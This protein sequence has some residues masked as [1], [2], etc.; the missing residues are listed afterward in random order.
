MRR[1]WPALAATIPLVL[2]WAVATAR[3]ASASAPATGPAAVQPGG[4]VSS[5]STPGMPSG[6]VT[7]QITGPQPRAVPG[8]GPERRRPGAAAPRTPSSPAATGPAT[9]RPAARSPARRRTGRS[10]PATATARAAST[11]RSGSGS[12]A[13]PAPRSS[14]SAPR[15]T[16]RVLPPVLRLVRGL[17]GRGGELHQPGQPRRPVLRL[18]HLPAPSTFNLVLTDSTKGWTQTA[19]VT[20]ASAAAVLG[21][22]HRRGALLHLQRRHPAADQ[23]RHGQLQ[24]GHGERPEHGHV[25]PDRDRHAEHLR[26]RP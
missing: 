18:G 14:R 16:A 4:P 11:P 21:R 2:G 20:L 24:L 10:R 13:T 15:S 5:L 25:Q 3:P 7:P 6:T 1:R 19:D 12:T 26:C 23:L 22:G 17:P 8:G 9:W